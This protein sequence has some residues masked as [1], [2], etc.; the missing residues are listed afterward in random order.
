[1]YQ[2]LIFLSWEVAA[3]EINEILV[4]MKEQLLMLNVYDSCKERKI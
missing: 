1:M 4:Q 3:A 2:K